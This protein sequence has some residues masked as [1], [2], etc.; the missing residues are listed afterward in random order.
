MMKIRKKRNNEKTIKDNR[1]EMINLQTVL[2]SLT[3]N[4]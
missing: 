1:G 3:T 2:Q 4:H